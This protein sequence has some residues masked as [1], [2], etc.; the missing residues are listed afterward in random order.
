VNSLPLLRERAGT[1]L[2]EI[3]CG[4]DGTLSAAVW[5][6]SR[7]PLL[8]TGHRPTVPPGRQVQGTPGAG[9]APWDTYGAWDGPGVW[10]GGRVWTPRL[11]LVSENPADAFPLPCP[12]CAAPLPNMPERLA[13]DTIKA[14]SSGPVVV[15]V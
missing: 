8:V 7:G 4:Q 11:V 14:L 12:D 3:R 9:T 1:P 13:A 10:A 5:R 15:G 2:V 6:T